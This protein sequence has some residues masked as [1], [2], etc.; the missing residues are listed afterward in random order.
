MVAIE[1]S[2]ELLALPEHPDVQPRTH[3]PE[4]ALKPAD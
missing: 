4:E 2:V 1:Q 3:G